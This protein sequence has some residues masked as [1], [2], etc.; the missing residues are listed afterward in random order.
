MKIRNKEHVM[1][2]IKKQFVF[3]SG[4][5]FI[6][7]TMAIVWV[8]WLYGRFLTKGSFGIFWAKMLK[9]AGGFKSAMVTT[10]LTNILE[11]K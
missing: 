11:Q 9:S 5:P 10:V 6:L 8:F 7:V 2:V 4:Y 1:P 3:W